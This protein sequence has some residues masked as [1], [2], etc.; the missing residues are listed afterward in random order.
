MKHQL[1]HI[2]FVVPLFL[3][4]G[5][6][7]A[8]LPYWLYLGLLILGI[9]IFIYHAY[10]LIVRL[11]VHSNYLWVNMI[12]VFLIAPLLI[13][14][15]YNKKETPRFAYELMLI[16]GFGAGGYHLYSLVKQLDVLPEIKQ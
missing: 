2:F 11:R 13:Y 6:F 9:G 12:H 1:F 14:I 16:L 3:A 5:F 10:K 15:G 7:K 8:S 4:I